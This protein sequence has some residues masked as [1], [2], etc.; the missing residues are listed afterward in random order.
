MKALG[1][2]IALWSCINCVT[3]LIAFVNGKN[4]ILVWAMVVQMI[5]IAAAFKVFKE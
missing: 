1:I 3:I 5:L 4:D 2:L